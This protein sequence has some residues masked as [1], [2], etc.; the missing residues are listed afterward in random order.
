[1]AKT[2]RLDYNDRARLKLITSIRHANDVWFRSAF[3]IRLTVAKVDPERES[4]REHSSVAT[5]LR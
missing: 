1:M 3:E 4:E 2:N 5:H